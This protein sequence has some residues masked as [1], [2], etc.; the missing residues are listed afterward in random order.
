M[1]FV[2][3]TLAGYK[4]PEPPGSPVFPRDLREDLLAIR[5]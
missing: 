1:L 4:Q 2:V 3:K 5:T